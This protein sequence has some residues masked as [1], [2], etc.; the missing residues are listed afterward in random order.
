MTDKQRIPRVEIFHRGM[1]GL[2]AIST[3]PVTVP[4]LTY[5]TEGA[6]DLKSQPTPQSKSRDRFTR[7]KEHR[8]KAKSTRSGAR[9]HL[10]L[11]NRQRCI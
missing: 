4:F 3:L 10:F 7:I 9:L 5:W 8:M 11:P 6:V 1:E 2:R